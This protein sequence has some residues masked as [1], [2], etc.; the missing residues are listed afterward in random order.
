LQF[1]PEFCSSFSGQ[2]YKGAPGESGGILIRPNDLRT[3]KGHFSYEVD[4]S[5]I[6]EFVAKV[7]DFVQRCFGTVQRITSEQKR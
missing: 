5:A 4:F 3:F 6:D 7:E 1:P 2:V